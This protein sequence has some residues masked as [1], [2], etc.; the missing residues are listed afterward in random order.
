MTAVLPPSP[1]LRAMDFAVPVRTRSLQLRGNAAL[2]G[3]FGFVAFMPYPGI[4]VGQR[5]ALQAGNLLTLVIVAMALTASWKRKPYFLLPLLMA[6]A[7]VSIVKTAMVGDGD[8]ALC[9]KSFTVI[10]LSVAAMLATQFLLPRH[11]LALMTGI[12]TAAILHTV[13]GIWQIYA[14]AHGQFPL[15][16]LYVN[17][18]FLS[19]QDNVETIV[20]YIQRPFGL[21]PEPSAMSS[22][23][24]P[25]VLFW[26]AELLGL[27]RLRQR[28]AR[29]Q[30]AMFTVAAIGSLSVIILSR[31]G[32]AMITLAM[33]ALFAA[34]W[35]V[36]CRATLRSFLAI[37]GVFGVALPL[38][39]WVLV[40]S[41]SAR[42][43]GTT[44]VDQSWQDRGNSL[45]VGLAVFLAGGPATFLF[46]IGIGL[47][48][49]L[50]RRTTDY[51][52]CWSVLLTY[53]YQTGMVGFLVLLAIGRYLLNVWRHAGHGVVFICILVVWLMGITVTTSYEHLLPLWVALGWLSVWPRICHPAGRKRNR[54]PAWRSAWS[55]DRPSLRNRN[56]IESVVVPGSLQELRIT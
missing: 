34:V 23:L 12:A 39:A 9:F 28:P 5:T 4:A 27:V 18:S 35:L 33:V 30:R 14:F 36:R 29:W 48:A 50:M 25:W 6:P 8:V 43:G 10:S 56:E 2:A 47:L 55:N 31:S 26:M 38:L 53:L 11:A 52:T 17:P 3:V 54:L 13:V 20:R 24:A 1:S 19:I 16:F 44:E 22:S 32:H 15:L 41:I 42:M 7:C 21:F 40:Q 45:R 49:P 51:I 37:L 46:G